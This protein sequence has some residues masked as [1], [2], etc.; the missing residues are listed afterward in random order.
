MKQVR[1]KADDSQTIAGA[2]AI[3]L[4]SPKRHKRSETR[5]AYLNTLAQLTQREARIAFYL[6][7]KA[8]Y[9]PQLLFFSKRVLAIFNRCSSPPE[10]VSRDWP[11]FK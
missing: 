10:N 11:N 4:D 7:Y 8:L 1:V 6:D 5:L 3:E 9:V 2:Y